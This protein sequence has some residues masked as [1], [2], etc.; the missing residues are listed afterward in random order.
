M[1]SFQ[2]D[3]FSQILLQGTKYGSSFLDMLYATRCG[4][5]DLGEPID[6]LAY[7]IGFKKPE[8]EV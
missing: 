8:R 6:D 7:G 2:G 1:P 5:T 4:F 3:F